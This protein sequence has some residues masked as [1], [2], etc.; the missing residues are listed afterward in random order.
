LADDTV[1]FEER[2]AERY[3]EA[4]AQLAPRGRVASGPARSTQLDHVLHVIDGGRGARRHRRNGS[5]HAAIVRKV[6]EEVEMDFTERLDVLQG[7]VAEARKAVQAAAAESREQLKSRIDQA[8]ADLDKAA[9][10][11]EQKADQ[12]GAA[13]R[14]KWAQMRADAAAKRDDVRAKIDKRNRELDAKD[15]ADQAD[16]AETEA[17]G[18]LDYADWAVRSAQLAMLDAVD[19][20]AHATELAKA[21]NV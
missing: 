11:T 5:G 21:A 19:A 6:P 20:R 18:A 7:R 17:A 13:A 1:A 14:S 3:G 15:A 2:H 9:H 16:W 8:E 10:D 4:L 12:A